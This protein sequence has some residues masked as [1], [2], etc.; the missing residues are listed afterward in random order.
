MS[1]RRQFLSNDGFIM[2]KNWIRLV[3]RTLKWPLKQTYSSIHSSFSLFEKYQAF[4]SLPQKQFPDPIMTFELSHFL[5][6]QKLI[7][8]LVDTDRHSERNA[9]QTISLNDQLKCG[10]LTFYHSHLIVL[11]KAP[12][13]FK[14]RPT[15][16]HLRLTHEN[17]SRKEFNAF[18]CHWMQFY[19]EHNLKHPP[20]RWSY[21]IIAQNWN[22]I[23]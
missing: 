9:E 18:F 21:R 2:Q 7:K 11:T 16:G 20:F 10:V 4:R 6:I 12:F 14:R 8:W 23:Q 1:I 15:S 19:S 22:R 5:I 13:K 17:V 3:R